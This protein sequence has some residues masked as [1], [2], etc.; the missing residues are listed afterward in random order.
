MLRRELE[1]GLEGCRV[2]HE[3]VLR[4]IRGPCRRD[5]GVTI[6]VLDQA[7]L[8]Q[9]DRAQ[10]LGHQLKVN[11]PRLRHRSIWSRERHAVGRKADRRG[12]R[13]PVVEAWG[14]PVGGRG[15]AEEMMVGVGPERT[16]WSRRPGDFGDP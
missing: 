12:L 6:A 10:V 15:Q 1:V 3:V 14:N 5:A 8:R 2:P 16:Q 9:T 7:C 4:H 13:R 11:L